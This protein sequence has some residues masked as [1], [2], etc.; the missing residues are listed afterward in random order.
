MEAQFYSHNTLTKDNC[1]HPHDN[2]LTMVTLAWDI[3]FR[4]V[5]LKTSEG[6]VENTV[7]WNQL[8]CLYL[9][10]GESCKSQ[11]V[12]KRDPGVTFAKSFCKTGIAFLIYFLLYGSI[13]RRG[14]ISVLWKTQHYTAPKNFPKSNN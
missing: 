12:D 1:K 5:F 6:L 11:P 8:I 3:S 14:D 2:N 7:E 4:W 10:I 13:C 9:E